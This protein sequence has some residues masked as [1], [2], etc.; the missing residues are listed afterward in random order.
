MMVL[1]QCVVLN[2][3][4]WVLGTSKYLAERKGKTNTEMKDW[5]CYDAEEEEDYMRIVKPTQGNSTFDCR[6]Q[7]APHKS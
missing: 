4:D 7:P 2:E 6:S 5:G 1:Q 3:K